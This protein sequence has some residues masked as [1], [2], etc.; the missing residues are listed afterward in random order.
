MNR[1]PVLTWQLMVCGAEG[2]NVDFLMF[3]PFA[4]DTLLA[5]KT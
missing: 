1:M 3:N 4:M 2:L 5:T